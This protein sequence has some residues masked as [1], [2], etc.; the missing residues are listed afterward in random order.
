VTTT[1]IPIPTDSIATCLALIGWFG[2][3]SKVHIVIDVPDSPELIE[4]SLE[5]E[6]EE[7]K[8]EDEDL[9]YTEQQE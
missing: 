9:K 5:E 2:G 7:P 3:S 1:P 4:V 8:L 6:E